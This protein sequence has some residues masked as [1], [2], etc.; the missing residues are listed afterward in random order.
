MNEKHST[1][2]KSTEG[3]RR[4]LLGIIHDG[5]EQFLKH[6]NLLER[7][8]TGELTKEQWRTFAVQ[9]HLAAIPFED[10][11]REGIAGAEQQGYP[12]L[13]EVLKRNLHDETGM[14]DQGVQHEELAH[15]TWRRNFYTR[16][17][18]TG[19]ELERA[20]ATM[21]TKAYIDILEG[22]VKSGDPLV[23]AGALLVLEATIPT[24]FR[25]MKEGRD[26]TFRESFVDME[27]D[28]DATR[29]TKARARMYLDDHILH[30]ATAH[31]PDLLHALEQP[32]LTEDELDRIKAGARLITEAKKTFYQVYEP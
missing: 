11:L 25:K 1:A 31:F 26:K 3:I 29:D 20:S 9:R 32:T 23:I 24:E 14:D 10:L 13:A 8:Q 28:D 22:I 4:F 6:N 15:N 16:L 2:E 12:E 21:G 19:A 17:G 7:L 5:L 30:D 27:G 18:I